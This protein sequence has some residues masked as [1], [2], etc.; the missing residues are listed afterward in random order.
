MRRRLL[1]TL[2]V[3]ILVA[4]AG[5]CGRDETDGPIDKGSGQEHLVCMEQCVWAEEM[6]WYCFSIGWDLQCNT[7]CMID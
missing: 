6:T 4:W 1:T 3:G 2:A 7:R 5:A